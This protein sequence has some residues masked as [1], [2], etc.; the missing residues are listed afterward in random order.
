MYSWIIEAHP[1][2]RSFCVGGAT[3][4][5]ESKT[6]WTKP[7]REWRI[8]KEIIIIGSMISYYDRFFMITL[9]LYLWREAPHFVPGLSYPYFYTRKYDIFQI[10][11]IHSNGF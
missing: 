2:G 1:I 10:A 4:D 6:N 9:S 3:A 8:R 5:G 11:E 7:A